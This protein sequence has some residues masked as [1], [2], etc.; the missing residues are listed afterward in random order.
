MAKGTRVTQEEAKKMWQLYQAYGSMAKVAK[1]MKRD[2][3]TVARHVAAYEA[4]VNTASVILT[5]TK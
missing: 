5:A 4:S 2:R 1:H 3:G